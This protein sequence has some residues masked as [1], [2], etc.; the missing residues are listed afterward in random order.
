MIQVKSFACGLLRLRTGC[1]VIAILSLFIC[2]VTY[3]YNISHWHWAY[4]FALVFEL[5]VWT[6]LLFGTIRNN[7]TVVRASLIGLVIVIVM[8]VVSF[9]LILNEILTGD[10]DW[11]E[12][13]EPVG[14]PIGELP[15]GKTFMA[16]AIVEFILVIAIY[17]YWGIVI[18]SFYLSL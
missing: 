10:T 16:I 11:E 9:S 4:A 17:V 6:A 5:S 7:H 14:I 12:T 18:Y 3:G 13:G 15:I 2:A 1:I 8:R